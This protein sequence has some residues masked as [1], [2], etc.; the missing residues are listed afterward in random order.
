MLLPIT[1]I[2]EFITEINSA[3]LEDPRIV[4]DVD[5]KPSSRRFAPTSCSVPETLVIV[6]AFIRRAAPA[7]DPIILDESEK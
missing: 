2:V 6:E 1:A 7:I 4:P 3:E 5:M